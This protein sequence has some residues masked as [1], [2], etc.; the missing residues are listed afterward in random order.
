MSSTQKCGNSEADGEDRSDEDRGDAPHLFGTLQLT[1]IGVFLA[2]ILY[3]A[4]SSAWD[5]LSGFEP[6]LLWALLCSIALR[7]LKQYIVSVCRQLLA[8]DRYI[9][10]FQFT[11]A[12]F[13]LD[14]LCRGYIIR[15]GEYGSACKLLPCRTLLGIFLNVLASPLRAVRGSAAD[16]FEI[17]KTWKRLAREYEARYRRQ[18]VCKHLQPSPFSTLPA[19]LPLHGCLAQVSMQGHKLGFCCCAPGRRLTESS[20]G[21]VLAWGDRVGKRGSL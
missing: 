12:K 1:I 14:E 21:S 3:A 6:S 16:I 2:N 18:Q 13:L 5:V 15:M 17:L 20:E 19:P 9:S 10:F 8:T 11:P 7:D 4:S